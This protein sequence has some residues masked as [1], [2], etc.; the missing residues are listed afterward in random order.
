MARCENVSSPHQSRLARGALA[1]PIGPPLMA[2]IEWCL[3]RSLGLAIQTLAEDSDT[4]FAIQT[5]GMSPVSVSM[6]WFTTLLLP[7]AAW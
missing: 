7:P 1:G 6:A 4:G 5:V 2:D 3:L